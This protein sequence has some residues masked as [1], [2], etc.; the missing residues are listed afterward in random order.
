M[1]VQKT[2]SLAGFLALSLLWAGLIA[3]QPHLVKDINL[4]LSPVSSEPGG[5]AS[6][7]NVTYF[8]AND[9]VSGNELWKTDGTTIGTVLVRDIRPGPQSGVPN[10]RVAASVVG[11]RML[12]VA[13]DGIHGLEVWSTDGTADGTVMLAD[14]APGT[15]SSN[16][17][18][19][20][21]AGSTAYFTAT[22]PATGT[23]LWQT[24]GTIAGT[25]LVQDLNPGANSSS[26][27]MLGAFGPL[28]V[29]QA[30]DGTKTTLFTTDGTVEGTKALGPFS[31]VSG[32]ALGTSFL[33]AVTT[34]TGKWD[35][36][37][38]DGTS[39]GT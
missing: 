10:D 29:F 30:F 1:S 20:P 39:S 23:E 27:R 21:V 8:F 2:L 14:I 32:I 9:G 3:A 37:K 13:T 33:F 31:G 16:P 11:N 19:G 24:D 34:G 35:L 17:V 15:A 6:I 5:F 12:F 7:G 38:T 26:P 28:L 4:L 18:L 36:M 22:A 25:R